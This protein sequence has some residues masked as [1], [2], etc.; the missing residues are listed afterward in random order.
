MRKQFLYA[1]AAAAFFS[2]QQAAAQSWVL[3]GNANATAASILGTTNSTPLRLHTNDQERVTIDPNGKVGIGLSSPIG[4]LTLLNNTG[5]T[6]IIPAGSWVTTA[7]PML[8]SYADAGSGNGDFYLLQ[9]SNATTTRSNIINRRA[10]GTLAAPLVVQN[11]DYI[12]SFQAS[13]YDGSAFQN[14]ANI[15]FFVDGAPSAGN[16][17][18]RIAFS[19]GTNVINRLQRMV[20][21]NDGNVGIGT[22]APQRKLHVFAGSAG[23]V[24]SYFGSQLVVEN[25]SHTYINL[26]APDANETAIMFGKPA[27]NNSGGVFYNNPNAVNGLQFRTNGNVTRMTLSST[28]NLDIAGGRLS[29]GTLEYLQDGGAYDIATNSDLIPLV[30]NQRS[31]G[32]G[33]NRWSQVWAVD[34]TINTSDARD[35]ANIRDLEYG[36]KEIMQL[37]A[38]KFNWKSDAE[39]TDK[40]GLIAQELQKVLPEVVRDWE[41]EQITEEGPREKVATPRLGV[42]YADIIPVVIKGMQEQQQTIE[43]QQAQIEE[44]KTLVSKLTRGTNITSITGAGSLGQSTPNP[45]KGTARISYQ[46]PS[47]SRAQLLLTDNG[48]K[49]IKSISLT[50]AGYVDVNTASLSSGLYN[51]TLVVDGKVVETKKLSVIR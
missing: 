17:P 5:A 40:I 51:Y 19:T 50:Q 25:S 48:G 11:N 18:L 1:A 37:R 13:G 29:F 44:L 22:T 23:N 30:D 10:R 14:A 3:T 4:R 38:T 21:K 41:Y 8:A 39:K 16:V 26:L 34:G 35:K 7:S 49:T 46:V 15:D 36:M 32:E 2:L 31:L 42:M 28:G 43:K 20:I 24:T 9:A 45:A 27:A 33:G 12:G 47:N 6:P